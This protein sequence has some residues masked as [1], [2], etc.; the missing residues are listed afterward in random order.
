MCP[1]REEHL[2]CNLPVYAVQR[3][4]PGLERIVNP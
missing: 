2:F 1:V 3:L 4:K